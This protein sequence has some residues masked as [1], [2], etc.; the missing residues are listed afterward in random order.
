MFLAVVAFPFFAEASEP[1]RLV[2]HRAVYDLQLD[3]VRGSKP[4][5]DVRGRLTLEFMGDACEGYATKFRQVT[6][7]VDADGSPRL[8]DL[9]ST[10]WESG[11]GATYKFQIATEVNGSVVQQSEGV[12]ERA[13]DG[14]ISIDVR[15]PAPARADMAGEAVFP[16]S[17]V[18]RLIQTA[19]SGG[20]L[21]E[22]R[23]YDGSETGEKMFD[24]TGIVGA[25]VAPDGRK[26]EETAVKAGLADVPRWPVT[27]S[28]F[29]PGPGERTPVLVMSYD[30]FENGISGSLRLDFG[31]FTLKGEMSRL[32]ILPAKG[33]CAR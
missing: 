31:E 8:T 2:P 32:E 5:S 11:D 22:V 24:T 9:R 14:G 4:V 18:G 12:A 25:R 27:I 10:T 33:T 15:R 3:R 30:L 16:T 6:R 26:V 13:G 1:V 23:L 20:R 7:I 17:H 29:E 21:L 19:R 28:Y